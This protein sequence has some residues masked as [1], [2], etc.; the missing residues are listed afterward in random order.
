M[1]FFPKLFLLHLSCC[2]CRCRCFVV[3]TAVVIAVVVVV[4][5][6]SVVVVVALVFVVGDADEVEKVA[7][8]DNGGNDFYRLVVLQKRKRKGR[9]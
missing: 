6:I 5:V 2:C 8:D 7:E 3:V 9:Q 4:V 1:T